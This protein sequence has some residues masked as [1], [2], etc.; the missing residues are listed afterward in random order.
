VSSPSDVE[1]EE[2]DK[3]GRSSFSSGGSRRAKCVGRL[4][5]GRTL[6]LYLQVK[7]AAIIIAI[8]TWVIRK[9][10]VGFRDASES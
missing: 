4:W 5:T 3:A 8:I 1:L 2:R 10:A 7:R 9:I 6:V